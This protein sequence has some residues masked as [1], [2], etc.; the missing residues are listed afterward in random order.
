MSCLSVCHALS[1][2]NASC[3]SCATHP[4]H[5]LPTRIASLGLASLPLPSWTIQTKILLRSLAD[6]LPNTSCTSLYAPMPATVAIVH[7]VSPNSIPPLHCYCDRWCWRP[8]HWQHCR[9]LTRT[10]DAGRWRP[11]LCNSSG[12]AASSSKCCS[13]GVHSVGMSGGGNG[14]HG[15]GSKCL[16][17]CCSAPFL[18]DGIDPHK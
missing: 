6:A 12:A 9:L 14:R 1:L 4:H 7:D 5:P 15:N 13:S 17:C 10:L 2:T 16:L 8:P 11:P 18:C 3:A